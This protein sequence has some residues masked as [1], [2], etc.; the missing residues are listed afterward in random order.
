[1]A[2]LSVEQ[3]RE[4]LDQMIP[5]MAE[6][7]ERANAARSAAT[8]RDECV[9]AIQRGAAECGCVMAQYPREVVYAYLVFSD[10]SLAYMMADGLSG[11]A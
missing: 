11:E 1:M 9:L 5:H 3:V 4:L 10:S 2:K 7:A 6:V 8:D